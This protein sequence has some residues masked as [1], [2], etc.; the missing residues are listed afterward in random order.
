MTP[1][2][3]P[4]AAIYVRVSTR[5]QDDQG[6]S[7]ETQEAA[8]RVYGAEHGYEVATVYR[9]VHTGTELWE[10]P[11]LTALR[12]V[13]RRRTV[14]AVVVHAIDRL[15]RDPVHLGVVLSEAEHAGVSVLFV[16]EPLDDSPEGQLIRFVRGYAAKVEH[17][18]I[19][20][21]TIRGR[22]QRVKEGKP[23]PGCRPLYGYRWRDEGKTGYEPDP[24]S[25]PVVQRIFREVAGGASLYTVMQRLNADDIP[26]P[27]GNGHWAHSTVGYILSTP[28][29]AGDGAALRFSRMST[30]PAALPAGVVP[31]LVDRGL[32]AIVRERLAA[33]KAAAPRNNKHP[34]ATL[35]RGGYI[36]CATCRSY[37]Q[38]TMRPTG[39]AYVCRS[40]YGSPG[41]CPVWSVP[42]SALDAQVWAALEKLI[43]DP[44]E[45]AQKLAELQMA[46]P[47]ADD[48]AAVER[49]LTAVTRRQ[50]NLLEEMAEI[51][52]PEIRRAVREK[53]T[54]LGRIAK[55]RV[56]P[57]TRRA[58]AP[59]PG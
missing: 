24:T 41:A 1:N 53:L 48:L 6:T 17:E 8:G 50:N 19:K 26:S 59:R 51:D 54:L 4:R 55:V 58:A 13:I 47:T 28:A 15:S 43:T 27:T 42:A 20:E 44:E 18:K 33:N 56:T 37:M 34:E 5:G 57:A 30:G 40:K 9:E 39:P 7:P 11:Q 29:Y 45:V 25:A 3:Q 16:T 23:I 36:R 2:R 21:R 32:F 52:Q 46:D 49:H 14:D 31:P 12:E 35:L 10:R 38:A 22:L